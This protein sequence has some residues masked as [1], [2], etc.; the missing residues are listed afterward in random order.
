MRDIIEVSLD[1]G[2]HDPSGDLVRRGS[3]LLARLPGL[4]SWAETRSCAGGQSHARSSIRARFGA[5]CGPPGLPLW[6]SSGPK[7]P[8]PEPGDPD[9]FDGSGFVAAVFHVVM[10][11]G[12]DLLVSLVELLCADSIHTGSALVPNHCGDRDG[13]VFLFPYFIDC[14]R[15]V[16]PRCQRLRRKLYFRPF[17]LFS[18]MRRPGFRC[19]F[20]ARSPDL[21]IAWATGPAVTAANFAVASLAGPSRRPNRVPLIRS[22]AFGNRSTRGCL[23]LDAWTAIAKRFP[24]LLLARRLRELLDKRL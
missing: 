8:G 2:V 5:R 21:F 10:E 13:S 22:R 14:P 16:L 12:P 19:R 9:P 3:P 23:Q 11:F 1:I 17:R 6:V 4:L 18:S 24:A 7:L 20:P 15:R